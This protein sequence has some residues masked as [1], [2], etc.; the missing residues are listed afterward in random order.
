MNRKN[1]NSNAFDYNSK[2]LLIGD[3][4]VGKT[5]VM[6]RFV[7][8]K[9]SSSFITTI[10]IDFVAKI[11]DVAGSKIKLQIWDTAGQ[12]RFRAITT[13]YFKGANIVIIIYDVCDESSFENVKY[14]MQTI[15]DSGCDYSG[16]ILVGNKIDMESSR[17]ISYNNGLNLAKKYNIPFFEC[18]AKK[19]INVDSIFEE[20]GRIHL[21]NFNK[22]IDRRKKINLETSPKDDKKC[23]S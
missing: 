3:S 12:E 13:S 4:S 8:D 5:S 18:S 9:F 11:I 17:Q 1:S 20:A 7:N 6:M 19:G 10:R 22:F 23:C 14:W 21:K 15:N 2:I 16:V